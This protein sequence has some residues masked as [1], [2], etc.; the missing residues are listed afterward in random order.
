M[1]NRERYGAALQGVNGPGR[2]SRSSYGS[3]PPPETPHRG[4]WK[5]R[6]G[7]ARH[8]DMNRLPPV[9]VAGILALFGVASCSSSAAPPQYQTPDRPVAEVTGFAS[10]PSPA[11]GLLSGPVT[12]RMTTTQASR[13]ALLVRQ[14]PAAARSQVHCEESLG[15]IYRIVFGAGL[16]AQSKAVVEG[17]RCDAA[18]TVTVA[19]KT[20]SW[21]RDGTCKLIRAVRQVLPGRAKATQSFDIGC[22][23]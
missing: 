15:L 12:V 4:T 7:M 9:V 5:P 11:G 18:V 17:Y 23:S 16:V 2:S 19:G 21:W 6:Q 8:T 14:L 20:S 22:G 3:T 13:L 10:A 1:V